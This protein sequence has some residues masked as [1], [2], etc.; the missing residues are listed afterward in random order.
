MRVMYFDLI[1]VIEYLGHNSSVTGIQRVQLELARHLLRTR[2]NSTEFVVGSTGRAVLVA[3]RALLSELL[4]SLDRGALTS[5][6]LSGILYR[7]RLSAMPRELAAGDIFFVSGPYW[8]SPA[9]MGLMRRTKAARGLVGLLCYDLIPI[10]HSEYCPEQLIVAFTR[11]FEV[12]VRLCDFIVAISHHVKQEVERHLAGKGL[13]HCVFAVPLAHEFPALEAVSPISSHLAELSRRRFVLFLSTIEPRKNHLFTLAVWQ[14]LLEQVPAEAVPDLV[15]VGKPG[16]RSEAIV[17]EAERLG[18][19]GGKLH[20]VGQLS[21]SE[22]RELYRACWLTIFPS[23]VEGWGLPVAES[24]MWG[25]PCIAAPTSS[26]PE[27]AGDF[28]WYIDPSD[29][30]T[31]VATLRTLIERPEMVAEAADRIRAGLKPRSWATVVDELE[32]YVQTASPRPVDDEVVRQ[33]QIE[34][35]ETYRAGTVPA[36]SHVSVNELAVGLTMWNEGW[37]AAEAWGRWLRCPG[38]RLTVDL[39]DRVAE[40]HGAVR[41][42]I[43]TTPEWKGR[44]LHIVCPTTDHEAIVRLKPGASYDLWVPMPLPP[45]QLELELRADRFD[46]VAGQDQRLLSVGVTSFGVAWDGAEAEVSKA[47]GKRSG[48]QRLRVVARPSGSMIASV[49]GLLNYMRSRFRDW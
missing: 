15:W 1:D 6:D 34:P 30:E 49:T 37:Y 46:P 10:T 45:G 24:L 39:G 19:L 47:P 13:A 27:V 33:M 14:K 40:R 44:E 17:G 38:G 25:K 35:G 43:T 31:G 32:R 3:E 8:N 4:G 18:Y 5:D 11:S 28:A 26:I 41:L 7:L 42:G 20:V 12:A 36:A 29:P 9:T 48:G 2:C 23:H 21:D 16:W 22:V